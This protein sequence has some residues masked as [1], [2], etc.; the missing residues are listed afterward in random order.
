MEQRRGPRFSTDQ[1]VEVTIFG[2]E[3]TRYCGR[4][5]NAS[6]RGLAI[7]LPEEIVPGT[8]LKIEIDDSMVLGEAVYC[9]NAG[10]VHLV[11][12][13]LDQVL[14]GLAELGRKLQEFATADSSGELT[15]AVNYR[16]C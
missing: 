13:E 6:R 12:V 11:G 5:I 8:A 1:P 10:M 2:I 15:N 16:S 4:I 7:E 9:R 3:E 14:C